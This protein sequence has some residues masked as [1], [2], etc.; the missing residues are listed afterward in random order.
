MTERAE[1]QTSFLS[2]LLGTFYYAATASLV[3]PYRGHIDTGTVGFL[4]V[5]A[6]FASLAVSYVYHIDMACE[7]ECI[8]IPNGVSIV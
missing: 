7:F 5:N 8:D 1:H 2:E 3:I 4:L 6:C